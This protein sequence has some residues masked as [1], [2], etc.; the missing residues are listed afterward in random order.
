MAQFDV[1]RI[2]DGGFAIDCQAESFA[3]LKTRFVVPLIALQDSPERWERLNP[4]FDING[5]THVMMTQFATALRL[6]D[7]GARVLSLES[8]RYAILGALDLLTTGV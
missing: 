4:S 7:L 3:Y 8:H 2:A 5:E 1:H 6:S